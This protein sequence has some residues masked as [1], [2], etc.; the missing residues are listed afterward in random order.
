MTLTD[1]RNDVLRG[2]FWVPVS[3]DGHAQLAGGQLDFYAKEF[4]FVPP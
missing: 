1:I 3:Y 4:H 2:K